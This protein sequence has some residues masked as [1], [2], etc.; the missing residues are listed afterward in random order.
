MNANTSIEVIPIE[1]LSQYIEKISSLSM[2]TFYRGENALF[3]QHNSS[4]LR[5]MDDE[6]S[7][8]CLNLPAML[9][10]FW[11][12]TSYKLS[13]KE[14]TCFVA[15]AQHHGLPTNLLDVTASPLV[16]L[17]FACQPN[18][19]KQ[20][21]EKHPANAPQVVSK[22]FCGKDLQELFLNYYEDWGYIYTSELYIDVTTLI[23]KLNGENFIDYYFLSSEERLVELLPLIQDFKNKHT[24]EF[25]NLWGELSHIIEHTTGEFLEMNDVNVSKLYHFF[26]KKN[27]KLKHDKINCFLKKYFYSIEVYLDYYDIDVVNYVYTIAFC[28]DLEK[29]LGDDAEFI[30]YLPNLLYRPTITFERGISQHGAFFYQPFFTYRNDLFSFKDEYKSIA[31]QCIDFSS[32]IYQIKNKKEILK[33]LDQIG[34]NQMNIWGDYDH[35]A[36]YIKEMHSA[37]ERLLVPQ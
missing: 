19:R 20:M 22:N 10:Q 34:I 15:F 33:A 16:A 25:M 31:R 36:S 30:A 3:D 17:F 26:S 14:K 27:K 18:D 21:L 7:E 12:E 2:E 29:Q 8:K 35:I 23:E 37:K 11:N 4:G 13:E 24:K 9:K 1:S 5:I 28:I 6:D 32:K